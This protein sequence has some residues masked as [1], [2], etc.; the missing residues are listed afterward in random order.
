MSFLVFVIVLL[1]SLTVHFLIFFFYL[2]LVTFCVEMRDE[3]INLEGEEP[4]RQ[5][6][7]V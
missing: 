5:A 6:L 4:E 7:V 3:G 2:K 1:E